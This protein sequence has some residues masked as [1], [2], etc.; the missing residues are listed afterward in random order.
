MSHA[1]KQAKA[2]T[3]KNISQV[4]KKQGFNVKKGGNYWANCHFAL[5]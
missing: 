1:I 2:I 3:D 5:A 4:Y